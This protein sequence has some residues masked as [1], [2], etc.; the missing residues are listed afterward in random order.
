M[1]VFKTNYGDIT[2][3]LDFKKAPVSSAN[4]LE[5]AKSGF[6]DNT[7]FHRVIDNFMI[8]GGGFESGLVQKSN[9]KP[10]INEADNGL[11]NAVGTVAM[12][13]TSDPHSATAQFFINVS[14]NTFLNHKNKTPQGWGYAVFGKVTAGMDVVNK[15]KQC[16]TT[17]KSGHQDVPI[18]EIIITSTTVNLPESASP[19]A[20]PESNS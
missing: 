13:R 3:E 11:P 18:D 7:I 14:D 9:G 16:R 17:S 20:T 4:F 12:A 15:I 8:Q 19:K 5:Y 2:I 10:I 6:Y 1:I